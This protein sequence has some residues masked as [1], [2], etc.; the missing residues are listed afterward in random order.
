TLIELLVVIAVIG[1]LA[2]L[3]LPALATAK[4]RARAT[5]CLNNLRE[6]GIGM[7]IYADE[8]D[9]I[10][11][12]D[13]F[14]TS[15]NSW[16]TIMVTNTHFGSRNAFLCPGY[17]TFQWENWLNIY[18]IR[19]D[20]P[21]KCASGPNGVLFKPDGVDDPSEYMLLGDTTSQGQRG[22]TARQYYMF[23]VSNPLRVVHARH[24][25][26]ANGFFLDGHVEPCGPSRLEGLG[27][28]AEYGLD[29]VV[30]YF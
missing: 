1:L 4:K 29:T 9:G 16:G 23:K 25:G 21:P 3:L 14:T 28:P 2:S 26:R 6:V 19:G 24:F 13:P 10:V 12:I 18:G 5:Q 27:I 30:G 7:R 8:N 20:P 11:Q 22:F 15:T 17:K